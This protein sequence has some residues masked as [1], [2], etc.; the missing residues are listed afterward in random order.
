MKR[1]FVF[2]VILACSILIFSGCDEECN[3]ELSDAVGD[4][5]FTITY[6]SPAGQNYLETTYDPSNIRVYLD[7]T[8]GAEREPDLELIRP[9]FE[10][11]SFG[12]F[13][14]TEDFINI[15][16]GEVNPVQI[17]NRRYKY[18]YYIKKDV[19]GE[20]TISVDFFYE[21][22]ACNT[23]WGNITYSLNGEVLAEY[24]DVQQ[25]EIVIVE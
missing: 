5:F 18:D 12:P 3:P 13:R 17:Y 4:E 6:Q 25:A 2:L 23:F 14:F 1:N 7:P 10:N 15:A 11:G 22:D 9:G 16:T 8:G 20:D 19:F 24:Q 21:V